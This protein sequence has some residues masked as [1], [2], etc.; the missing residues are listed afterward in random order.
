MSKIQEVLKNTDFKLLSN[1]QLQTINTL[2]EQLH[3][4]KVQLE[5]MAQYAQALE[6][7]NEK[8]KNPVEE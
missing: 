2:Q 8:L 1:V 3:L 5:T 4:S 7:E 6:I